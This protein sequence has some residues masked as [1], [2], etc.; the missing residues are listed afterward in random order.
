MVDGGAKSRSK[1][2]PPGKVKIVCNFE[3]IRIYCADN[4][5]SSLLSIGRSCHWCYCGYTLKEV[6]R[7]WHVLHF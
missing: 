7:K 3:I 1:M 6:S 5:P 4:F 2:N